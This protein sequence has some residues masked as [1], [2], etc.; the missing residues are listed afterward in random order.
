MAPNLKSQMLE[1]SQ[2]SPPPD[3]IPELSIPLSFF[4][5]PWIEYHHMQFLGFYALP[6]SKTEVLDTI[7]PDL[8]ASFSLTLKHFLPIAGNLVLPF[9]TG[10]PQLNYTAGDSVPLAQL[11]H[12][13]S[14][15]KS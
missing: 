14:S 11:S 3:T 7:I 10:M 5:I 6:H 9:N 2:V 15:P 12:R 1:Q 4:D 8:K 13:K